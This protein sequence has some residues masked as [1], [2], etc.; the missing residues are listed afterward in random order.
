MSLALTVTG[1]L[2]DPVTR[3]PLL[4][5]LTLF[6]ALT[7]GYRVHL[8]EDH[9]DSGTWLRLNHITG[10]VSVQ[11]G[12]PG[13]EITEERLNIIRRLRAAAPL[14]LVVDPD[15]F[16]ISEC[17]EMGQPALLYTHPRYTHLANRPGLMPWTDLE[18][19]IDLT[20]ERA[21]DTQETPS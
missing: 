1:I 4:D 19:R 2:R 12:R 14:D 9:M 3:G 8:M 5:G 17:F 18:H 10:H 21:A 7:T 11:T 16:V 13:W 20:R 15:P 6:S